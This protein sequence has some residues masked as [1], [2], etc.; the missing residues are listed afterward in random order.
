MTQS[1][2]AQPSERRKAIEQ[3]LADVRLIVVAGGPDRSVLADGSNPEH[4]QLK[5]VRGVTVW[6][7]TPVAFLPDDIHSIHATGSKLT[8][9]FHRYGLPLERLTDRMGIEPDT[10]RVL[11]Y[12][13]TQLKPSE[14]AA[15]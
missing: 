7:G 4:A 12:N 6:P 11:R 5:L 10:G 1:A 13:A 3:V 2:S 15:V 14:P 9:H 8:L